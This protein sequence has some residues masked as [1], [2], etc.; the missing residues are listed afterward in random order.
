MNMDIQTTALTGIVFIDIQVATLQDAEARGKIT[1]AEFMGAVIS[2]RD[3]QSK[4]KKR[5]SKS[6]RLNQ[7]S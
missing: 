5:A 2:L 7:V 4:L 1:Q 6:H 3:E